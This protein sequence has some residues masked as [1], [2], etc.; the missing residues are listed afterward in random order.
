MTVTVR[1]VRIV[2][3]LLAVTAVLT[4]LSVA[5]VYLRFAFGYETVLGLDLVGIF[6]LDADVSIPGWY[7]ASALLLASG[8]VALLALAVR[9]E[10]RTDWRYWAVL[11]A[12]LCYLSADETA[13]LHEQSAG[14]LEALFEADSFFTR[15]WTV[16][17]A[18]VSLLFAAAYGRFVLR[19][20]LWQRVRFVTAGIL[21]V[22]GAVGM[23]VLGHYVVRPRSSAV[24]AYQTMVHLEEVMEKVAIILLIYAALREL[25]AVVG[26]LRLRLAPARAEAEADERR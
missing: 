10:G 1:P 14:V 26:T 9:R 11:A 21:F 19:L 12:A 13:R 7:S 22:F 17:A 5:S 20:G 24:L 4:V 16:P 8:V 25:E 18:I 6:H 23:E 3:A 15:S 2:L